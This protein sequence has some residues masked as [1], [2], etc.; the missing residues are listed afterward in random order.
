VGIFLMSWTEKEEPEK[1]LKKP[2][3]EPENKPERA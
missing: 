3:D 2:H 1:S